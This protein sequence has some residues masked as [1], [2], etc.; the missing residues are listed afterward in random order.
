[1]IIKKKRILWKNFHRFLLSKLRAGVDELAEGLQA[2]QHAPHGGGADLGCAPALRRI[3]LD[4]VCRISEF[5][6]IKKLIKFTIFLHVQVRKLLTA[7]S[8]VHDDFYFFQISFELRVGLQRSPGESPPPLSLHRTE[9]PVL[10]ARGW[11][12][13]PLFVPRHCGVQDLTIPV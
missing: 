10:A 8:V 1:M 3:D 7:I 12:E 5:L 11:G 13:D 4:L 2:P 9:V 6:F